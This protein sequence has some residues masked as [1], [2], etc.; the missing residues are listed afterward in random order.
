MTSKFSGMDFGARAFKFCADIINIVVIFICALEDRR[1]TS[2]L[3]MFTYIYLLNIL[4]PYNF[5]KFV[6]QLYEIFQP[7]KLRGSSDLC[8]FQRIFNL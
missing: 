1:V 7:I 5:E 3:K 6:F 8:H 4:I 2:I